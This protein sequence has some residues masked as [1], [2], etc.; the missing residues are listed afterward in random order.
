M[1]H[2][3]EDVF[4]HGV[5]I[6]IVGLAQ[7][8]QL[9]HEGG[10]FNGEGVDIRQHDHGEV[11]AQNGLGNIHDIGTELGSGGRHLGDETHAVL[12]GDGD[13]C[14]HRE[15]PFAGYILSIILYYKSALYAI[16]NL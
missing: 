9:V 13:N 14:F 3:V 10:E 6:Q 5:D 1:M 8:L 11:V 2:G 15:T 16:G 4:M 12:T 7:L